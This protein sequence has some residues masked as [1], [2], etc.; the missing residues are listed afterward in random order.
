VRVKK[1]VRQGMYDVLSIGEMIIDFVPEKTGVG[2]SHVPSFVKAPGGAPANVAVGVAKL[3][4]RAAFCGKF[5]ADAF[6]DFLIGVLEEYGV[7][8]EGCVRTEEAKTGL[9]FIAVDE[10]GEREFQFYRDPSADMLL[11]LSD[12]S[13]ELIR[14]ARIV[15][16]GSVTQL[17][18]KAHAATVRALEIAREHGVI[19][20]FDV[21]FRL[22]IWRGREDEGR[23]K[24]LDTIRLTDVLKVSEW[25]LEFLTGTTDVE[26]G[27]AQLLALGPKIVFVTLAEKGVFYETNGLKATIPTWKVKALDATGAGDA[28]VAGFLRQ[29]ADRVQGRSLDYSLSIPEEIEEMARY[30]NAVGAITVSRMGAIPALPTKEEVFQFMYANRRKRS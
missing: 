18:P 17:L 24:V 29:L 7:S 9:A 20:S 4:G 14:Q 3:G 16:V 2:L 13:E 8:T 28:F 19:T 15:H 25:E 12:L 26:A 5:G 23:R 1:E 6:G 27:S 30:A 21:N 10:H 22:G 11:E